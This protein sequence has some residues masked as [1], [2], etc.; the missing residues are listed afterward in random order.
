MT[1]RV[2]KGL[3]ST[4]DD[5]LRWV[6]K[7]FFNFMNILYDVVQLLVNLICVIVQASLEP[8]NAGVSLLDYIQRVLKNALY[9]APFK[10][11]NFLMGRIMVVPGYTPKRCNV[12][13]RMKYFIQMKRGQA[14]CPLRLEFMIMGQGFF[15]YKSLQLRQ[16]IYK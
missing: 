15:C 16:R 5:N 11:V 8:S 14:A 2:P 4:H 10:I 3:S 9:S 12:F 13:G 7:C 1:D 6:L